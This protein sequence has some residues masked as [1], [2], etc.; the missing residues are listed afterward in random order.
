MED[1]DLPCISY[2]KAALLDI[3]F[4]NKEQSIF[5]N[6]DRDL[7]EKLLETFST[8][9]RDLKFPNR[10][11]T[12]CFVDLK[13]NN[14]NFNFYYRL[15]INLANTACTPKLKTNEDIWI[16]LINHEFNRVNCLVALVAWL[17]I[18]EWRWHK[19]YPF[20]NIPEDLNYGFV[21]QEPLAVINFTLYILGYKR[22][23][24]IEKQ[25]EIKSALKDFLSSNK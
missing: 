3:I 2:I 8:V 15:L 13:Q 20:Y 21:L 6:I 19:E 7:D 23:L 14:T 24:E 11:S 18:D 9:K 4:N 10:N 25:Q 1:L 16:K 5:Q 22:D 12:N 17:T